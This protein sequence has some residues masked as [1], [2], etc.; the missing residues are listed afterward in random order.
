[1][2]TVILG[3]DDMQVNESATRMRESAGFKHKSGAASCQPL[4][5]DVTAEVDLGAMNY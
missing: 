5:S 2:V 3:S 4:A 1:M